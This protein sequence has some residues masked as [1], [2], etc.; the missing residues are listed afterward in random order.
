MGS[1]D[2][3]QAGQLSRR[4]VIAGLGAA[5]GAV[6]FGPAARVLGETTEVVIDAPTDGQDATAIILQQIAAAPDGATIRFPIGIKE[7]RYRVDGRIYVEYRRGL[8]FTG[9]S[10]TNPATIWTDK[11]GHD[12][13]IVNDNKGTSIRRHWNFTRCSDI[14]LRNLRVKGPNQV[15]DEEG[16]SRISPLYEAEHAFAF[17][18]CNGVLVEDCSAYSVYGDGC[19]L[20]GL[21]RDVKTTNVTIR[22]VYTRSNG[23]HGVCMGNAS[24]VLIDGLTVVKGGT[25]G[26]DQE[27]NGEHDSIFNVEIK[28]SKIDVRTVAFASNGAHEA[29]NCW[30]HHNTVTHSRTW[31]MVSVKRRDG[32]RSR[33]WRVEDNRQTWPTSP[34]SGVS[35]VNIDNAEVR[36]NYIE[37]LPLPNPET[38]VAPPIYGVRFTGCQG[39]LAVEDNNFTQASGAYIADSATGP[40]TSS[41]NS[42]TGCA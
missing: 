35:F 6:V 12:V 16:Y 19:Y 2:A 25:C 36:R 29:S 14:T 38:G 30:I 9:P 4:Q 40:V 34:V 24:N 5:A 27:P 7:G 22:R 33:D 10:R 32:G 42:C 13:G 20:H 21:G 28:N 41:G 1:F 23:R 39:L 17:S 15:R 37:L 26:V 31:P 18:E 11:V 8:T 3:L